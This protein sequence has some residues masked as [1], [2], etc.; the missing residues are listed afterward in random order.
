MVA[1]EILDLFV[2][3]RVLARQPLVAHQALTRFRATQ[4][5]IFRTEVRTNPAKFA[6][7][8]LRLQTGE[9]RLQSTIARIVY[10]RVHSA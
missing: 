8:R 3:V 6:D 2:K 7:V 9:T 10:L 4:N 1:P 5:A